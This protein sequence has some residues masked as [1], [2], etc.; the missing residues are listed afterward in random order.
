[1]EI[2]ERGGNFSVR[3]TYR[4]FIYGGHRFQ[5]VG[6]NWK[7]KC[8]MKLKIFLCLIAKYAYLLGSS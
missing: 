2:W 7:M 8:M 3:F 1:M 5:N 6:S 4:H